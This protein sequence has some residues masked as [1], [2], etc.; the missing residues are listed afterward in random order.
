MEGTRGLYRCVERDYGGR[1]DKVSALE[2][3]NL[4]FMKAFVAQ[5]RVIVLEIISLIT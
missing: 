3:A 5:S 4:W 2:I 1:L